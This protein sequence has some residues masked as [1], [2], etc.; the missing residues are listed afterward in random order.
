[1]LSRFQLAA[2]ASQLERS[3]KSWFV[4]FKTLFVAAENL[5]HVEAAR[6]LASRGV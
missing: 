4:Q 2:V 1:M 3:L 5:G 6:L